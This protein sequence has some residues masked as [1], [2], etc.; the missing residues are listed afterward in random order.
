MFEPHELNNLGSPDASS[1]ILGQSAAAFIDKSGPCSEGFGGSYPATKWGSKSANGSLIAAGE[2]SRGCSVSS[3]AAVSDPLALFDPHSNV[4]PVAG[5]NVMP[6]KPLRVGKCYRVP[7]T[8]S[9][10]KVGVNAEQLLHPNDK[11]NL[12]SFINTN[13]LMMEDEFSILFRNCSFPRPTLTGLASGNHLRPML[14]RIRS[15]RREAGKYLARSSQTGHAPTVVPAEDEDWALSANDEG[16]AIDWDMHQPDSCD[17]LPQTALPSTCLRDEG[18][19]L[20]FQNGD[21]SS[22]LEKDNK[23]SPLWNMND[24]HSSLEQQTSTNVEKALSRIVENGE[25]ASSF[26]ELC[27]FHM[28]NFLHNAESYARETELSRRIG[29]WITK[30]EPKLAAEEAREVFNIAKYANKVICDVSDILEKSSG[31]ESLKS[32]ETEAQVRSVNFSKIVENNPSYEVCRIF[33]ACL[34]LANMGTIEISNQNA[35]SEISI[36]PMFASWSHTVNSLH[37]S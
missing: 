7:A 32:A 29:D 21:S 9:K 30:L 5:Y 33:T 1:A 19:S 23:L 11:E 31:H 13:A 34:Q 2:K 18:S 4:I 28:D 20:I 22:S 10:V 17:D 14:S 6:S 24:K 16:G 3:S 25:C 36:V 8:L 35:E 12:S 27:K 15:A 26:E 37:T